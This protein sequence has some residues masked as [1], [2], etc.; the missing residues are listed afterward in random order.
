MVAFSKSLQLSLSLLASTAAAAPSQLESRSVIAHDKVVGFPP[1]VPGGTVG[2]VYLA[3]KPYLKVVNGCVPYPAV[4]AA[5]NTSG[6]LK[7]EGTSDSGCSSSTGQVYVRGGQYGSH[8][9]VMYSWYFPKDEP[10]SKIG[11]RHDWEGVIVWLKDG[12]STNAANIAAVCPSAHGGWDCSTN[13]YSLA[14]TSPLIQYMSTWPLDHSLSL[15]NVKGGQQPLIAWESLTSEARS[16]LQNTDFGAG[17]VPFK[18][19]N[20]ASNLAKATF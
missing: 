10:S 17:N 15:T 20:F 16:A 8:Y 2:S 5:G 4:D 9:A 14:G 7:P 13:A 1:Q 11:H 19:G 18:E 6:G 3:Y 12:T